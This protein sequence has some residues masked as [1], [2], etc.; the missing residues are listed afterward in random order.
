MC[1]EDKIHEEDIDNIIDSRLEKL[2]EFD[3]KFDDAR[4]IIK[5]YFNDKKPDK[6]V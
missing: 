6:I 5:D 3:L 2:M 1:K 4:K